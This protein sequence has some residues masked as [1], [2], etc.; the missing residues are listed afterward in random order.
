[1]H[2][3][4]E[5]GMEVGIGPIV[6][7]FAKLIIGKVLPAVPPGAATTDLELRKHRRRFGAGA[8][9]DIAEKD[10]RRLV[11]KMSLEITEDQPRFRC[12][13]DDGARVDDAVIRALM[14]LGD[15]SMVQTISVHQDPRRLVQ[16]LVAAD[17][18]VVE[19]L[20]E[21]G[22]ELFDLMMGA[23]AEQIIEYFT[24]NPHYSA[25]MMLEIHR[26]LGELNERSRDRD[27]IARDF[28]ACY[29]ELLIQLRG[30]ARL[31]GINLPPED[32]SYSLDTAYVELMTR[33]NGE[34]GRGR[35][36]EA[37]LGESRRV[38]LIGH[39]GAGKTTLL[40]MLTVNMCRDRLPEQLAGWRGIL[41]IPLRLRDVISD[42][43]LDLPA[44]ERFAERACPMVAGMVPH[45]WA[46]DLLKAGRAALLVDGI[47]EVP[48]RH[49]SQV[50]TWLGE[51]EETFPEARFVVTS[52]P[53][54][55]FSKDLSYLHGRG[56]V[57]STLEPMTPAQAELFIDR[58]YTSARVVDVEDDDRQARALALKEALFH[59][60]DL[61]R[62]ATNPLLCGMLCALNRL[63]NAELPRGRIALYR[64]ALEMLLYDRN[65]ERRVPRG[66]VDLSRDQ[67]EAFLA[68]IAMWMTLNGRRTISLTDGL[69]LIQ[70]LLPRMRGDGLGESGPDAAQ[71]I[72][73][74]LQ[75]RSGMLQDPALDQLEFCHPSFQ[76]YLA[77]L[78]VFRQNHLSFLIRNVHDSFYHD[79]MIMVVGQQQGDTDKQG[80]VLQ[81]LIRRA[82]QQQQPGNA[83]KLW[84]LAA[85]CIADVDMV[86]PVLEGRIKE[87][88]RGLLPPRN[89]DEAASLAE[90]GD[91]ILDLLADVL[92]N[93][94][95]EPA[96]AAATV[97]AAGRVGS[98]EAIRL[99]KRFTG[100]P[101]RAVRAELVRA[102]ANSR[103]P[104]LYAEQIL[105]EM[106]LTGLPVVVDDI[107]HLPLLRGLTDLEITCSLA[108]VARLGDQP[109][110]RSLRLG[111]RLPADLAPLAGFPELRSLDLSSSDLADA[112]T[113]ADLCQLDRLSVVDTLVVD[114]APLARLLRLRFLD[115]EGTQVRDLSPLAA[116]EQLQE[117]NV[118]RTQVENAD[119]LS[120][121]PNLLIHLGGGAK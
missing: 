89:L 95:L 47:D 18:V 55:M 82:E 77:G 64:V 52:R 103:A 73:R 32:R 33:V 5:F 27:Q 60:R 111:G 21:T 99:L 87:E 8:E 62:L 40:D 106:D 36:F 65:V 93:R 80:K 71:K 115:L 2:I 76:D 3:F 66:E 97:L 42:G 94:P 85:A 28:E 10:I 68:Q 108:D 4:G 96:E 67:S 110:L 23:C 25:R 38:L 58:W 12:I 90:V 114:V 78:E 92:G 51:L 72:L 14:A 9:R 11:R 116:L 1:M 121:L 63:R 61:A 100:H 19:G 88:T 54:S 48:A 39:A 30:R 17:P 53:V 24:R 15:I 49:R 37:L 46:W 43:E 113:L 59:R 22:Q 29:R 31:F 91:V 74:H 98:P 16:A 79:V 6:S 34:T 101:S 7:A 75:E 105:A 69:R 13:G 120:T 56:Y 104:L 70:E 45:G 109:R 117:L 84:L 44:P 41:P 26:G 50:L 20:Q 81:R 86:D 118:L 107:G 119:A 112:S 83:R 57:T 35:A 102:W